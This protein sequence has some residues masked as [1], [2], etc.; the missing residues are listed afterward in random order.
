MGQTLQEKTGKNHLQRNTTFPVAC[1]WMFE[2]N[3]VV[4]CNR[5]GAV[6][7]KELRFG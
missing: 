4:C 7:T 6:G 3:I 2:R 5:S 1:G